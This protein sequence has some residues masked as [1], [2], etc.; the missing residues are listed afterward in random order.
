MNLKFLPEEIF[1]NKTLAK[2]LLAGHLSFLFLFL[3][4]QSPAGLFGT[5]VQSLKSSGTSLTTRDNPFTAKEI[6]T[7]LFTAYFLARHLT[8]LIVLNTKNNEIKI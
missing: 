8:S 2:G 5:F 4:L 1:L 7:T 6:L 3:H